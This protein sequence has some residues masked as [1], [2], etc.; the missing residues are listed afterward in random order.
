MNPKATQVTVQTA[1]TDFQTLIWENTGPTIL[2]L[3][4]FPETPHV[5]E[6]LAR[7]L[8]GRGYRV[9]A[10]YLPGY[11]DT[12]LI[13]S[14]SRITHL[15]D[16]AFSLAAFA[17]AVKKGR[18]KM[19]LLGHDWGAIAAYVT[20]AQAPEL[21]SHLLALS[22]P[23]PKLFL[24]K[25]LRSPKQCLQSSYIALFQLRMGLPE[26]LLTLANHQLLRKLCLHWGDG[27][28]TSESY[29]RR[30]AVFEELGNLA[31]PLGYY[32]GLFPLLSGSPRKWRRSM[33][34]AFSSIQ[35]PTLV[36]SGERDRCIS[37]ELFSYCEAAPYSLQFPKGVRYQS[38]PNAG[39]FLPIDAPDR[40]LE[41]I[42]KLKPL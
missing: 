19:L 12:P 6:A 15:D 3:H 13:H 36:L 11:G 37:S 25:L 41:C 33:R 1:F 23:P 17:A 34:L 18:R 42:E 9:V 38:L 16:L 39:H 32:R 29:F 26:A 22:V 4:G 8:H 31:G 20:A 24:S 35:V 10:P 14:D 30:E 2:L 21:F 5:F 28:S 27:V 40:L 7:R